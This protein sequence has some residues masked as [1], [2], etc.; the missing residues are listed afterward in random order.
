MPEPNST[1][2]ERAGTTTD[3]HIQ[4]SAVFLDVIAGPHSGH[5]FPLT[6]HA[7]FTVGRRLGLPLSLPDDPYISRVHCVI[8]VNGP[9]IRVVDLQSRSGTFVNNRR[10]VEQDLKHDD[11]VRAGGTILKIRVPAEADGGGT[12]VTP[13]GTPAWSGPPVIP[14]YR[15][16]SELGR[17]AMGVVYRATCEAD[18]ETVAIKTLL[19]TIPPTAVELGR[20]RREAAILRQ[21]DH[22][23]IVRFRDSGAACGL[24]YFVMEFVPG[25]NASMVTQ[26]GPLEP[27]RILRWAD[28]LLDALAH[29]H[30]KRFVHRDLKPGNLLLLTTATGEVLKVSDFGLARAYE[31]SSCS[32]LTIANSMGGTPA[33][34][35]P[36]QLL[37]FRNV[38]PAADLYA[39]AATL[40][41]LLT[42]K[43]V[44]DRSGP[45]ADLLRRIL[46]ED[47]LPLT[48]DSP[49]LPE[50]FG[51]VIRKA[52]SREPKD[53]YP[54]AVAMRAA[55]LNC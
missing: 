37:D 55:L 46:S 32:G 7:T 39:V 30:G 10:V 1:T 23:N 9:L 6:G 13:A 24:L 50:P 15:M 54:S 8:E 11:E 35:P 43:P 3:P 31:A 19:P 28:Q 47:P 4:E 44:Y 48:P 12:L 22:P 40:F 38:G 53:R 33:F 20:F 26:S 41:Y 14:G 42:G 29:A 2:D 27:A 36:E 34:M 16:G 17:G 52:L 18:G 21:L 49:P 25:A 45:V 5:S 51:V